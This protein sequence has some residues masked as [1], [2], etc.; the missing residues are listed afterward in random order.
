M[1][2]IAI[3]TLAMSLL[4]TA[5]VGCGGKAAPAETPDTQATVEAAVAATSAAQAGTQATID[6]AVQATTEAQTSAQVTTEAAAQA[7]SAAQASAQA[8]TDAAVQ[9]TTAAQTSAQATT[10][11]AVQATSVAQV[12]VQATV[13]AAVQ[14]TVA[15]IPTSTPSAEYV[16]L[17]EEELAAMIDLAVAEATAGP[18]QRVPCPVAAVACCPSRTDGDRSGRRTGAAAVQIPA[19]LPAS[20]TS[21]PRGR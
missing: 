13:D 1:K 9:A 16:T 5:T 19:V 12:N 21:L 14:A 7:A 4:V 2:R 20:R 10:E 6:A 17:T 8:T 3:F 18:I 11:A 15:A